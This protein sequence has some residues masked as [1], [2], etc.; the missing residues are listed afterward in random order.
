E[1]LDRPQGNHH[2]WILLHNARDLALSSP[3]AALVLAIAGVEVGF[4][5]LIA[6]TVKPAR[7]LVEQLSTPP[8]HQM[9]KSYLPTL[10][11]RQKLG[12]EVKPPPQSILKT[13]EAAIKRRNGIVHKPSG[14]TDPELVF[15]TIAAGSDVL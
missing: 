7:W 6:D 8:V 1:I 5:Q 12:G 4:K 15:E 10:S 11:C 9:L 14:A 13:L 3:R 2:G